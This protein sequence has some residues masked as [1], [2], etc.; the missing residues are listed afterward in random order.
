MFTYMTHTNRD[1]RTAAPPFLAVYDKAA[2][3]PAESAVH[4]GCIT[5]G[6]VRLWGGT[7]GQLYTHNIS[8]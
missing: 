3:V 8:V 4:V 2:F 7:T 1:E 6:H 5:G